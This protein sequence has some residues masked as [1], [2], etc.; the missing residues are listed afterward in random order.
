MSGGGLGAGE[1]AD[2]DGVDERP[3]A[4]AAL[5][6][7][8]PD[9]FAVAYRMLGSVA[10]AED[11]V[12]EA[13]LRLHSARERGERIA[14]PR[15]YLATVTTRLAIDQLRSARAR[16]ESYVGDWLPE[17]LVGGDAAPLSH[18][19]LP[20][21]PA[22]RAELSDSLS[23]AFLVL[24]ERLTPEERAAL[25][26]HD[27][28]DYGYGEVGQV[29]GKSE[30]N[31]RQLAS[32]ARRH[33]TA[34]RPRFEGSEERRRE[35]GER[36]FEAIENGDMEALEALLARDVVLR[37]DGGGKVPALAR[38][39]HGA[40]RVGRTLGAWFR[41]GLRGD[42]RTERG[43]INGRPGV[44]LR[45]ADG[46]VIGT[47]SLEIADDRVVGIYAVVNPDKLA[48]LGTVGDMRAMLRGG[49]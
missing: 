38:A 40:E 26:L 45:A 8:R 46:G 28:F 41:S 25:L 5:E 21:D 47:M 16:R 34:G 30:A 35:L 3:H 19:S 43:E 31:A 17:P 11:I 39:L 1:R 12:Q 37:G 29:I 7:L 2:P 13:L 36:F 14:S 23:C 9:A 49:R 27:V 18:G 42:A 22:R 48:H 32:R 15:A 44:L 10:D 6:Q 20:D 4:D 24:L 33:V